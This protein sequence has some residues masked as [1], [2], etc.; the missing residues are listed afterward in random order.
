MQR[1]MIFAISAIAPGA[2][3]ANGGE[4]L[5]PASVGPRTVTFT[6]EARVTLPADAHELE[7]PLP[8]E[9]DQAVLALRL[10][11]SRPPT[12]MRLPGSG[13]RVAYLRVADPHEPVT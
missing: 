8:R 5:G 2:V 13:D 12:V 6:Y 1:L 9:E 7:L 10:T 3:A 4:A 11:G